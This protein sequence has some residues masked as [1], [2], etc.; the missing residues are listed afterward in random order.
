MLRRIDT[1]YKERPT[2]AELYADDA[3]LFSGLANNLPT[4]DS[5][6]TYGLTEFVS[7]ALV[8]LGELQTI[9]PDAATLKAF[10]ATW[11]KL[12]S[13]NWSRMQDAL[14]TAYNPI[15]NYDRTETFSDVESVAGTGNASGS[16]SEAETSDREE[17]GAGFNSAA[18]GA[19]AIPVRREQTSPRRQSSQTSATESTTSRSLQHESSISGNIGVTTSQQ[20]VEAEVQLRDKFTLY[21]LI[22]DQFRREICVEVW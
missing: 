7:L 13:A 9:F 18:S 12:H 4:N 11:S 1:L 10:L 14:N 8:E 21:Y 16:S 20:M 5:P 6:P 15:H 19:P 17:Y 22:L 2:L 3:Q